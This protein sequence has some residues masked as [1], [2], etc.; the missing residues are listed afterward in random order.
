LFTFLGQLGGIGVVSPLYYFLYYMS[1][2]IEKL[3]ASDMRLG[4]M[5]YAL[6]LLPTLILTYYI[7]GYSMF[8]WPTLAG[9]ESW[10]FLWQMF[11]V[12]ISLIT[13]FLSSLIP[14][15]T[16]TDRF[17]APTR[18]LPVVRYTVGSLAAASSFVWLV[19]CMNAFMRGGILAVFIP[20]NLPS[21]TTDF[22][23]FTREF[24]KFDEIFLFGNTFLWLTYL[25]W[26]L[27]HAGML[28]KSWIQLLTYLVGS[29]LLLGP[30]ATAGLG[31][32][33]REHI[34]AGKRHRDAVTEDK[35]VEKEIYAGK[36]NN[37]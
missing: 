30:G 8:Y 3:Q 1:T 5:N 21:Q 23:A 22:A 35:V 28:Q 36:G 37:R 12:W 17:E 4:K 31:W 11:P 20:Q 24:L 34:L 27:K 26:D 9:R 2:P 7:P 33:W 29:V 13:M 19:T 6:V 14:D 16:F 18:D 10:L 25:F 15:T 32:L